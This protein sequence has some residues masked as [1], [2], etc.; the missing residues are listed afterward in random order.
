MEVIVIVLSVVVILL[1][2]VFVYL[3]YEFW[4][5]P[6]SCRMKL[7]KQGIRGPPTS[8]I[9]GNIPEMKRLISQISQTPQ[10]DGPITIFPY[11][12]KWTQHY[13]KLFKFALGKIQILYVSNVELVK[14]LRVH[15]SWDLGKPSYL[16]NERGVLLG[17]G[18]ITTN[19]AVWSHQRQTVSPELY[20]DRVK[21]MVSL[22]V[23]SGSTMVESWE[24]LIESEE[25]G[26][27][28]IT[29][30]DH[31]R[32]FTSYITSKMVFGDDHHK[33]IKIVPTCIALIKTMG[34]ATTLGL[35]FSR[36]I[37]TKWIRESRRLSKEVR[38]MIMDI[39]K[40]RSGD[41]ASHQDILQVIFEG[42]KTA[43]LGN[44]TKEEFIVDNCKD[45]FLAACEVTAI[46]AIWGLMLLASNPEWQARARAEVQEVCGGQ[47]PDSNML[48]KMPVLKMVIQEV[49]RLYPGVA[50]VSREAIQ[51]VK[52]GEINIPK[53]VGI[54]IWMMELHRDPELWGADADKFNPERFAN[55]VSGACKS[56]QAY[57]PFGL[58]ARVCP[59]QNLAVTEL[60]VLFA[61][62]LCNF[63]LTISPKYRHS[64]KFRLLLEPEHG[65][66]L[67]IQKI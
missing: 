49:L 37:P 59:G 46:A 48:S 30:D 51:D 63:K 47:V 4:W 36:L 20:L 67:L 6:E 64:P 21:D 66:D 7:G 11:F 15:R 3:C 61:M 60:K 57:I 53:G 18:L 2:N 50:F 39:V 13:G 38:E 65:V 62:L 8:S 1:S 23:E 40:A 41:N 10:I 24:K 43:E 17:K 31:V 16:Q 55:G 27:C 52:L 26:V 35:P 19:G 14:Q 42:S 54:W 56:P 33:G 9:L 34:S 45:I 44:L 22:M 29:I 12:N 25:G 58:G 5:K 32:N 28:G